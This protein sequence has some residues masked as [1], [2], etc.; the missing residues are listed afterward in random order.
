[1]N[2]KNKKHSALLPA[3]GMNGN[4]GH[5]H[6]NPE[7][8]GMRQISGMHGWY[9]LSIFTAILWEEL[10][11]RPGLAGSVQHLAV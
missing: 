5:F 2:K 1:M 10:H 4:I 7:S 8:R 11:P 6:P 9:V 3:S